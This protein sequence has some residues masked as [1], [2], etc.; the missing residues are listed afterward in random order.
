MST[1][2]RTRGNVTTTNVVGTSEII[3]LST[4]ARTSSTTCQ[5]ADYRNL[6]YETMTDVTDTPEAQHNVSHECRSST[7]TGEVNTVITKPFTWFN[8]TIP[9]AKREVK[10]VNPLR[11][12]LTSNDTH[13]SFPSGL[14]ALA[15][16]RVPAYSNA[17]MEGFVSLSEAR[18]LTDSLAVKSA[19]A[20]GRFGRILYNGRKAG[21]GNLAKELTREGKRSLR[22]LWSGHHDPKSLWKTLL[23]NFNAASGI[24][25]EWKYGIAPM[26]ADMQ[27]AAKAVERLGDLQRKAIKGYR[28]YG[29]AQ[30]VRT[31][32][33]VIPYD[34]GWNTANGIGLFQ[35]QWTKRTKTKAVASV[36]RS[37]N[38]NNPMYSVDWFTGLDAVMEINGLNPSAKSLWS[39]LPLSFVVDWFWNV[40]D[41]LESLETLKSPIGTHII[42]S[43]SLYSVK[44]ETTVTGSG[45]WTRADN[46][47]TYVGTSSRKTYTRNTD[48]L[49][50]GPVLYVPPLT[51]PTKAGQWWSMAQICL[52]RIRTDRPVKPP[53]ARP[54]PVGVR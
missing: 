44:T 30:E 47:A 49:T 29:Q 26:I 36:V 8:G 39:L 52:Q 23:S 51:L 43:N 25:M 41:L 38:P 50:G 27:A 10:V 19:L 24:E 18:E 53:N 4:G 48:P 3:R 20:L 15:V 31:A 42:S 45:Y 7:C 33:G 2:I 22:D 9:D 35:V 16:A 54:L 34:I 1:R 21:A 17:M 32:S 13:V 12:R 28:V 46:P 11:G 14:K 6:P 40:G 5:V 37:L